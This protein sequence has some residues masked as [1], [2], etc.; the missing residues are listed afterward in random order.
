MRRQ[1]L[2]LA[3]SGALLAT[4]AAC[5]SGGSPQAQIRDRVQ[6]FVTHFN[7]GDAKTMLDSDVPTSFRRT[8]SDQD[9]KN[10]IKQAQGFG[11][12]LSVNSI[13][14]IQISGDKATASVALGTGVA[15]LPNTPPATVPFVKSDGS[16]RIDTSGA[17]A[18]CSGITAAFGGLGV[19]GR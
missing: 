3:L 10:L 13:D 1:G 18:G 4:V 15:L 6:A 16:W 12:K 9:A 19:P 17:G 7:E 2:G 11:A 14:N 5:S 8:C